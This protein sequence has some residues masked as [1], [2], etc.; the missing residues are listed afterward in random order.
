MPHRHRSC[1]RVQGPGSGAYHDKG[2]LG[3]QHGVLP[4]DSAS[5]V[6]II[7]FHVRVEQQ[8]AQMTNAKDELVR[9]GLLLARTSDVLKPASLHRMCELVKYDTEELDR[10]MGIEPALISFYWWV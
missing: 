8:P 5:I 4:C 10:G 1:L 3:W 2:G 6:P 7:D 9:R